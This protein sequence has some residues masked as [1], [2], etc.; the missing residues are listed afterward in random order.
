MKQNKVILGV[1]PGTVVTGY[2]V[3]EVI[4]NAFKL[5]TFGAI[6]PKASDPLPQK[7]LTIFNGIEKLCN[8]HKPDALSVETQFVKNNPQ[9]A[10]KL[11][12]ARGSIIVAAA[13][14]DIDI[15]EYAPMVAKRAVTGNGHSSKSQ[16]QHMVKTL[17]SLKSLPTPEDA[18]DALALAIAHANQKTGAY[19]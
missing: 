1:D 4:G 5:I 7:Y 14:N 17:L 10:I 8:K 12:M 3:I 11:G 2:G 6:K 15:F 13:K 16:V 19:V 18:A 9:T